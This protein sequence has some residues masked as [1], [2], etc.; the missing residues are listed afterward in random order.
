MRK[1]RP[2]AAT[3][4][5]AALLPLFACHTDG[6]DTADECVT[7]LSNANNY[8]WTGVLN[9]P[10]FTTAEYADVNI[11]FDTLSDDMLCHGM[12]PVA[13]VD[14]LGMTRFPN[15]SWEEI[16]VGLTNNSLLQSDTNGY[17]SCEPGDA[18]HCK[19]SDFSFGGTAYDV[20]S[21]YGQAGGSFLLVV[22]KGFDPGQGG[23]FLAFL[24]PQ[25][26]SD[27]TEISLTP[28]CDVVDYDVDMTQL[29]PTK[30]SGG[31]TNIDWTGLTVAGNG[32][33][34][35]PGKLDQVLVAHYDALTPDEIDDQFT[36]VEVLAD[37][38]YTLELTGGTQADLAGLVTADGKAFEGFTADGTWLM[39]LRCTANCT[40]PAP[41]FM[42]VVE[43][44]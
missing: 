7:S 34:L 23:L 35:I 32:E 4:L 5:L 31:C 37:E 20:V 40:N 18:T 24:D 42:T 3:A 1:L 2:A 16:A 38:L 19:L 29:T 25:P 26:T 15:L 9:I 27:V 17:V 21:V 44:D 36:D 41:M 6:K 30:V 39:G 28:T 10:S 11:K 22:A 13:D 12:D 33:P 14:N 8:Q 43:V